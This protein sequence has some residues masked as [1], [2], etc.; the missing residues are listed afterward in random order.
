MGSARERRFILWLDEIGAGDAPLVGTEIAWLGDVQRHLGRR[1]VRVPDGF[2]V[3]AQAY[4][5]VLREGGLLPDLKVLMSGLTPRDP[6]TIALR[7]RQARD[8]ICCA[9]LPASLEQ[10]I[11]KA[12]RRLASR[13]GSG[14]VAVRASLVG[15]PALEHH[16]SFL[17][18]KGE[19]AVVSACRRCFASSF[20]PAVLAQRLARGVDPVA[21]ALAIM[22][23]RMVRS[24]A[25]CSGWASGVDR[26]SGFDQLV[27]I[28]A[29]LGIVLDGIDEAA[30]LDAFRVH[31]PTL[32]KGFRSVVDRRLGAKVFRRVP[33]PEFDRPLVVVPVRDADRRRSVLSD[34]EV[35]ELARAVL[36]VEGHV[37]RPVALG[38][39]KDGDG[40][41]V[42]SGRLFVLQVRPLTPSPRHTELVAAVMEPPGGAREVL[43]RGHGV[44]DRVGTGKVKIVD[45]AARLREFTVGSVL[46]TRDTDPEW[47][48]AM[49]AS[50]AVITASGDGDSHAA[51][52]CG[53]ERVAGVVGAGPAVGMLADGM[54]ITVDG[55]DEVGIVGK[56]LWPHRLERFRA[57]ELPPLHAALKLRAVRPERALAEAGGPIDGVGL[58]AIDHVIEQTIGVHPLALLEHDRLQE[59]PERVGGAD[60]NADPLQEAIRRKLGSAISAADWFVDRLASAIALVAAASYRET[61]GQTK[62]ETLVRLSALDSDRYRD[63]L[64]GDRYEPGPGD[65]RRDL[66][67][68][69]RHLDPVY[70]RAFAL[71]CQALKRVRDEMGLANVGV[72]VPFCRTPEEGRRLLALMEKHGL[73]QNE[74]GFQVYLQVQLPT[75]PLL[76]EQFAPLFDG[77]VVEAEDLPLLAT[78]ARAIG[79]DD[80]V[81]RESAA[82]ARRLCGDLLHAVRR[83][84][85]RRRIGF[86]ARSVEAI[87]SWIAFFVDL[88]ADFIV[89]R[90]DQ[91]VA[92]W[93]IAACAELARGERKRLV[94]V[95][96]D[97]AT[98]REVLQLGVPPR[99]V[100]DRA[101]RWARRQ[102]GQTREL[103]PEA[104]KEV[105][106]FLAALTPGV[107]VD[108]APHVREA[109]CWRPEEV[110]QAK[111]GR[112][113]SDSPTLV[114]AVGSLSIDELLELARAWKAQ[115]RAEDRKLKPAESSQIA[116]LMGRYERVR[117]EF[118][119]ER[120]AALVA[121]LFRWEMERA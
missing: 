35:L 16:E 77:F 37:G 66:R 76:V 56:G 2:V 83:H 5:Q 46:V 39:A 43:F 94:L 45:D 79:L 29:G 49:R 107:V 114:R 111:G 22:V 121:D 64:G 108:R 17:S 65:P 11:A 36:A 18:V 73:V 119:A 3:T 91:V 38:W 99:W 12:Y 82:A 31:K 19:Y 6:A 26:E 109:V 20:S 88:G 21:F 32:R 89:T 112:A 87:P 72:I 30:A 60:G 1:G 33:G 14:D 103:A 41:G 75:H 110:E 105:A 61:A 97:P 85:P 23:Q 44:G 27:R 118:V 7:A 13:T 10:E 69:S 104:R 78:G 106:T 93:V 86:S 84:R 115:A 117:A 74:N 55:R 57:S 68:A 9:T 81:F 102:M 25:A 80:R 100:R 15:E 98:G 51:R 71:E 50:A 53:A 116:G 92:A 63:L 40:V 8:L 48:V 96:T 52:F 28:E 70:G 62:G 90:S 67:G 58:F 120:C 59:L 47:E 54:E 113:K 101:A 24:D 42:G 4:R 95:E 34:D